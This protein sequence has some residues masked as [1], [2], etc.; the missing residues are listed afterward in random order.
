MPETNVKCLESL[1]SHKSYIHVFIFTNNHNSPNEYN[2]FQKYRG[3]SFRVNSKKIER[4]EKHGKL[5]IPQ[6]RREG[7]AATSTKTRKCACVAAC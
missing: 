3:N 4:G 7:V 5:R 2:I 6:R 1:K